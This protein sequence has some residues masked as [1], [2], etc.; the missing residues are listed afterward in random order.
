MDKYVTASAAC[1]NAN[2]S[3]P[4]IHLFTSSCE[5]I[6]T[7]TAQRSLSKW[8]PW[9]RLQ[10]SNYLTEFQY[11]RQSFIPTALR[12][13]TIPLL[14]H[15]IFHHP[16]TSHRYRQAL[17]TL[18]H[19]ASISIFSKFE[20]VCGNIGGTRKFLQ[21]T[22]RVLDNIKYFAFYVGSF[23]IESNE[24]L[25]QITKHAFMIRYFAGVKLRL[26]L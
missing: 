8:L 4:S 19:R 14:R 11:G 20:F 10:F 24:N 2:S 18:P 26:K 23:H 12:Y 16:S 15:H 17:L 13:T 21:L 3:T 1:L 22:Q 25:N 7:T 6:S 5:Q 9:L